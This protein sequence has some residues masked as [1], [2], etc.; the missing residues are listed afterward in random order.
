MKEELLPIELLHY[1]YDEDSEIDVWY[2]P[3][4][5]A[6]EIYYNKVHFDTIPLL[7]IRNN[8]LEHRMLGR[9]QA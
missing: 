6:V 9:M 1:E 2:Y 7:F 8:W 4:A 3:I 5:N